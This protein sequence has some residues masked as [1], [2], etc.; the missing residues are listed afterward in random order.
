MQQMILC[1]LASHA[2]GAPTNWPEFRGPH[3]DGRSDAA[4]LPLTWSEKEHVVWK[5]PI[6]GRGHS[7]PVVWENQVWVTTA[8]EDGREMSALCV[9]RSNGKVL[10]DLKLFEVAAPEPLGNALNSYASPSPAIEPGRVYVHFGS[11]GTASIDTATGKTLWQR[12]D[13]PCQ[14]FRGPGSSPILFRNFLILTMD[15]FDFQYVCALDTATGKTVWKTD[16]SFEFG[17][18]DGDFRKAY[19]TP[20][21]V[22]AGRLQL[23]S[24]GAKATYSYDPVTGKELW[25]VRYPGFSN[26]SRP[27]FGDGLV[28]INTGFGKADLLAVRP[29]GNGDVTDSKVVWRC[30]KGVSLKPSPVVTE[31]ML[32]MIADNGILTCLETATGNL[33]WMKRVEGEFS[34]SPILAAGR[35]YV[36]SHEGTATVVQAAKTFVQLAVNTLDEG[37]LA[38]PAAAGKAL[39]LRTKTHLYRIE[40]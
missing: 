37:C 12:R 19:T 8:T 16:R 10:H 13:L 31:G 39:F 26:A 24:S 15:G 6:H 7:T 20:L 17:S 27:V 29:D 2:L 33:V 14:H 18:L 11:Y 1:L 3:G 22:D 34:A 25:R 36:F 21:V 35:I 23:V 4:Q 32:F 5:T 9:D 28:F 30:T 38:S 40:E